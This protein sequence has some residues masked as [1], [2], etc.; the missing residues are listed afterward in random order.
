MINKY[1]EYIG[2]SDKEALVYSALL[3]MD[4]AT[5]AQLCKETGVPKSTVY[6][7][8]ETLKK[9]D[10]VREIEG[11]KKDLFCAE[12]PERLRELIADERMKLVEKEKRVEE[13]IQELNS[14]EKLPG[15]KPDVKFFEGKAGIRESIE[16]FVNAK[17][18][19]EKVDYGIYSYDLMKKIFSERDIARFD[20]KRVHDNI[21]FR[22]IYSG[23]EVEIPR[24]KMQESIKIDQEQFP[25][26]ADIGIFNDEVRFHTLGDSVW[27]VTIKN[28]EIATTLKSLIE[29]VFCLKKGM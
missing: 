29:Y 27:G 28:K 26:Q 19:S 25:I 4:K 1:L 11:G 10:L 5:V 24:S 17:F 12:S 14:T 3:R 15:D 18:Y 8:L 20:E 2:F 22:A 16:E 9:K 7:V 21:H 23:Y 13:V 6:L